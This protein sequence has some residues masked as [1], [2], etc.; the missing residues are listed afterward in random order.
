MANYLLG[1]YVANK[2]KE[3]R[4]EGWLGL[5]TP[6]YVL[7]SPD[8]R[9]SRGLTQQTV[10]QTP[11]FTYNDLLTF[12][13][14]GNFFGYD[15]G[16]TVYDTTSNLTT[17][18]GG[19]VKKV[20][21]M[22]GTFNISLITF[23]VNSSIGS[24]TLRVIGDNCINTVNGTIELPYGGKAV[25][26]NVYLSASII[27]ATLDLFG[28]FC[29]LRNSKAIANRYLNGG[30]TINST[31]SFQESVVVNTL[32]NTNTDMNK[33]TLISNRTSIQRNVSTLTFPIN[34]TPD[35]KQIFTDFDRGD[36][37][38]N[39][40]PIYSSPITVTA[41]Y[42]GTSALTYDSGENP[43]INPTTGSVLCGR[44]GI[45]IKLDFRDPS[46]PNY[47]E[48]PVGNAM[49]ADIVQG[50]LPAEL[51]RDIFGIRLTAPT[52][53]TVGTFE[54]VPI[55]L[56]YGSASIV[57]IFRR[58][59]LVQA[60]LALNEYLV[61]EARV[62]NSSIITSPYRNYQVGQDDYFDAFSLERRFTST[63]YVQFRF[64]LGRW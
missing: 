34:P 38:L 24:D 37:S 17:I 33:S 20:V 28:N 25:F 30:G 15:T 51:T 53:A 21:I 19:D 46:A 45:G 58:V 18:F 5:S 32:E 26:F 14:E 10:A 6:I 9:T 54:T 48:V 41:G 7:M 63:L 2:L 8:T 23:G 16:D 56:Q 43:F 42:K 59:E 52:G 27:K 12:S 61:S 39:P 13:P 40:N 3:L 60:N 11:T 49:T 29:T 47:V 31:A 44:Y 35:Q 62:S 50:S 36:Y 57:D 4:S 22:V 55:Y 1:R 64:T